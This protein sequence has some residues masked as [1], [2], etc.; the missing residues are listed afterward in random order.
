MQ[1]F[2]FDTET[3]SLMNSMHEIKFKWRHFSL[4]KLKHS[5]ILLCV[6]KYICN[7]I[8]IYRYVTINQ[9]C[10]GENWQQWM[11]RN[12]IKMEKGTESPD[13]MGKIAMHLI[14]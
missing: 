7:L 10:F 12:R 14:K 11:E 3:L 4:T 1:S 2:N 9:K 13:Q 6:G 5:P 8:R